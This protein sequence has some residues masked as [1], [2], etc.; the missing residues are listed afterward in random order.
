MQGMMS[1]GDR[2]GSSFCYVQLGLQVESFYLRALMK[3]ETFLP[4]SP[5]LHLPGPQTCPSLKFACSATSV[6]KNSVSGVKFSCQQAK[7][8]QR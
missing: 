2:L 8:L 5:S 4:L 1:L 3:R 6:S 7:I